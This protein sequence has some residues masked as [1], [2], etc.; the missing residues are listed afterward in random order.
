M[1]AVQFGGEGKQIG[2]MRFQSMGKVRKIAEDAVIVKGL[3]KSPFR[4][5]PRC[6]VGEVIFILTTKTNSIQFQFYPSKGCGFK[7]YFLWQKL[8]MTEFSF[9]NPQKV[10]FFKQSGMLES[11]SGKQA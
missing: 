3:Q 6:I 10:V 11:L 5:G 1:G 9:Q 8:S 2:V 4:I 7:K